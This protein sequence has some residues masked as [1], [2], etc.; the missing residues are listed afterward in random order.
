MAFKIAGSMAFQ[1]A[2]K[3][4]QAGAARAGDARRGRRPKDTWAT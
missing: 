2:A 4:G 3:K 1:D